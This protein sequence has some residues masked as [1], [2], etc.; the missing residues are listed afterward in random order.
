MNKDIIKFI[1]E[2][3]TDIQDFIAEKMEDQQKE[4]QKTM[5]DLEIKDGGTYYRL[6]SDGDVGQL[7]FGDSYD[8]KVREMGNAFLTREE[9]EFERERRKVET[10]MRRYARPFRGSEGRSYKQNYCIEFDI[11]EKVLEVKISYRY[12]IG[13]PYFETEEI[14]NTV[15]DEIGEDGLLK[16]WFGV[17]SQDEDK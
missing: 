6:Y 4:N 8:E 12:C 13:V 17:N 2:N 3:W 14:A 7:V 9:A 15:I 1:E 16:Y 11:G 5:W 10:I